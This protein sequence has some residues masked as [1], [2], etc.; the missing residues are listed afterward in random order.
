MEKKYFSEWC[1]RNIFQV[2]NLFMK[3]KKAKFPVKEQKAIAVSGAQEI[4]KTEIAYSAKVLADWLYL[5]PAKIELWDIFDK[6][7]Q[8]YLTSVWAAQY[9]D[10]IWWMQV[11]TKTVFRSNP[12]DLV[13]SPTVNFRL[14]V[15][16]ETNFNV[17]AVCTR[18]KQKI[19]ALK[20]LKV[21]N[22][23]M[24]EEYPVNCNSLPC[25]FEELEF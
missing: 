2:R 11:G 19:M 14:I 24:D 13:Y 7:N 4:A 5:R 15:K 17:V 10:A 20:L 9:D 3:N 12:A 25:F 8:G 21:R 1:S 6:K 18:E 22:I 23:P 16:E